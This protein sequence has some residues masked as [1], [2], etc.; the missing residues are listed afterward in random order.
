MNMHRVIFDQMQN[1]LLIAIYEKY[2][3]LLPL[4]KIQKFTNYHMLN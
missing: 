1:N 2:Q 4:I 3:I